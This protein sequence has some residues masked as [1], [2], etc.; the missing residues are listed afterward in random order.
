MKRF[1][2]ICMRYPTTPGDSYLT[3]ELAEALVA[4][5]HEV[6]VLHLDWD[7]SGVGPAHMVVNGVRV[8][9]CP[10]PSIAGFGLFA[11][12]ASKF[13]LSGRAVAR[14]ARWSFDLAR[15]DVAVTWM[16]AIAIAPLVPMLARAG[17][18]HRLL[19]I[20]DFFPDHHREI[21]RMPGGLVYRAARAWEQRLMAHFTAIVCTLP[22]NAAYL[23]QRYRLRDDQRVLV[24][25]IWSLTTPLPAVD[26]NAVRRRYDL[27]P[28]RPIAVFG[29]QLA[30]GRGIGQM[31]DAAGQGAALFL[32]VGDGRRA[33][34]VRAR[35]V[36]S[37]DVAHLPPLGRG[38]Y[39]ELLR[40]CDVGM[41]ATVTGVTSH[42]IPSKTTD[43]LRAGLPVVA[44][45]EP[46]N[47]LA[48]L[49]ERYGVGGAVALGN[50]SAFA[51]EVDRWARRR[52]A[53]RTAAT[54]CLDEVFDVRHAVATVL[55]AT[56]KPGCGAASA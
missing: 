55:A 47:E 52:E 51:R 50:A 9:R 12:H 48:A 20:W 53:V 37:T 10:A 29:G 49:L 21:G 39:L 42:S 23:R 26:R 45:L 16:P 31:L 32:F 5:G 3:S 6:E 24:T 35:A 1:L 7:E 43:Y 8:V 28:D 2:L 25:P 38:A 56:A 40:A 22:G 30:E 14:A 33:E 13:V 36:G 41:A 54:R 34:M 19:F 46:R 18:A 4:A 11:R 15:F 17:I 44:A 27:P